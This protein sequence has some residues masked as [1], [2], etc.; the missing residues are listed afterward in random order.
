MLT[1]RDE[2]LEKILCHNTW[3]SQGRDEEAVALM[4]QAK[5]SDGG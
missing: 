1:N 2:T 3:K 4:K 5:R